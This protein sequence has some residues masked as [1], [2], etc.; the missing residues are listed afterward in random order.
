MGFGN[1]SLP[2]TCHWE[3]EFSGSYAYK[4]I[5]HETGNWLGCG[6]PVVDR[7][8]VGEVGSVLGLSS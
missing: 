5:D 2:S 1:S 7:H 6:G 3:V 8:T 4:Y